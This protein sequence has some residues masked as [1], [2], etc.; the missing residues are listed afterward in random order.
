MGTTP[1]APNGTKQM[2]LN[3]KDM[4]DWLK[5]IIVLG[6]GLMGW[7]SIK[8]QVGVHTVELQGIHQELASQRVDRETRDAALEKNIGS[9]QMYLASKD[10]T[11]WQ[12]I[13]GAASADAP[14]ENPAA[15]PASPTPP[16]EKQ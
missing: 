10:R 15:E 12:V 1:T 8:D 7:Q 3:T 11:Y 6:A 16:Q 9:I 5:I 13:A 4:L 14:A 2:N